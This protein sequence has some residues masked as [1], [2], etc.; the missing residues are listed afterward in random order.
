MIQVQFLPF[1]QN[2]FNTVIINFVRINLVLLSLK[3]KMSLNSINDF[4]NNIA[5]NKYNFSKVNN[6]KCLITS[7]LNI[8]KLNVLDNMNK[9]KL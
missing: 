7:Y 8:L 6:T 5:Y 3:I 2:D 9:F 1:T 4:I